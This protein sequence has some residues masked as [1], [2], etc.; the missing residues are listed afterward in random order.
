LKRRQI[1]GS[2]SCAIAT[3]HILLQVVAKTKWQDV[4]SLL[5]NVSVVGRKLVS[6]QPTELVIGNIVR[7]ILSTIRTEASEDRN[8]HDE[9]PS[10][11]HMTPT[12]PPTSLAHHWPAATVAKQDS[13]GGRHA[14]NNTSA[15]YRPLLLP[16]QSSVN[17][18][19]SLFQLL[20]ASPLGDAGSSTHGASAASGAS[21]PQRLK[22]ASAIHALRTEI[23]A[24]IEEIKD[25]IGA[26][27]DNIAGHAELQLNPGDYI[28]LHQ[29]SPTVQKFILK[30]ATKRK[31]TVLIANELPR[32][33]GGHKH[34]P[35][36]VFR[37][38][39]AVHGIPVIN[40]MNG[41]LTAYMSRVSKV[42]ISAKG[43]YSNGAAIT[44]AGAAAIARAACAYG[45][46]VLVLFG[47]YKLSPQMP[48]DDESGIEWASPSAFVDFEDGPLVQH[49]EVQGA[50]SEILPPQLIDTFTTNL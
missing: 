18:P 38:K 19:K 27:D 20:S 15:P 42:V 25:E 12:G 7:R 6:A 3:A 17:I 9:T 28:L 45:T 50:S 49:V 24:A 31:F 16:S 41:G 36:T 37:K 8:N 47:T 14:M 2:E 5:N 23:I 26:T 40:V 43:I 39:L 4:D 48:F 46:A 22:S 11:G 30:A 35:L 21:T 34:D 32:K 33:L 13:P 29:P 44:D 10:E 1:T